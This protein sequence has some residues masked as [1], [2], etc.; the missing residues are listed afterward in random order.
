LRLFRSK[1]ATSIISGVNTVTISWTTNI[2]AKAFVA[3]K[4]TSGNLQNAGNDV[5]N[6]GTGTSG[7]PNSGNVTTTQASELIIGG[8]GVETADAAP[9][10][11]TDY[12]TPQ[13]HIGTSGG[14]G[15]SNIYVFDG[16]RIITATETNNYAPTIASASWACG[17]WT[18][19]ETVAATFPD[20]DWFDLRPQPDRSPAR[21]IPYD[22]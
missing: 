22:A 19:K 20:K 2:T 16:S 8:C 7:A 14:G 1:L 5:H 4:E 13:A 18:F 12:T 21:M 3:I 15:A 17:I 10:Q 9:T 11:D 6:G